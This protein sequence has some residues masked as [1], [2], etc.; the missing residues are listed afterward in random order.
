MRQAAPIYGNY[1]PNK[2]ACLRAR[3]RA[4]YLK[5]KDFEKGCYRIEPAEDGDVTL[6]LDADY[7]CPENLFMAALEFLYEHPEYYLGTW[8]NHPD[9]KN[10]LLAAYNS[11]G[12]APL[13][14]HSKEKIAKHPAIEGYFYFDH[15]KFQDVIQSMIQSANDLYEAA[16]VQG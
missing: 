3:A 12:R 6:R 7:A 2:H 10:V 8:V 11:N 5:M 9:I 1:Y 16:T 13:R 14:F 4:N 15:A